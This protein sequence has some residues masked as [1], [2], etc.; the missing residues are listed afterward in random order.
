MDALHTG[1]LALQT[2]INVAADLGPSKS[3]A[4]NLATKLSITRQAVDQWEVCPPAR[5]L[6]VEAATGISRHELRPDV[7]GPAEAA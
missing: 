5:V 6:E 4:I 3:G 1:R 7:F 2:A